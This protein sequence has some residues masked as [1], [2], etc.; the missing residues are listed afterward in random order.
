M[1]TAGAMRALTEDDIKQVLEEA[2]LKIKGKEPKATDEGL[3]K[4]IMLKNKKMSNPDVMF[5]KTEETMA[6]NVT[7]GKNDP[8]YTEC[9]VPSLGGI[10][11][12]SGMGG[13][14]NNGGFFQ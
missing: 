1:I 6:Q 9:H 8:E 12:G 2:Q 11:D 13:N 5:N 14:A 7:P 4:L 10:N 3:V